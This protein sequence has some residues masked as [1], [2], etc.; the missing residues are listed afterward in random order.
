MSDEKRVQITSSGGPDQM[1]KMTGVPRD[2]IY[3]T[4]NGCQWFGVTDGKPEFV[5][6]YEPLPENREDE[7]LL[8]FFSGGQSYKAIDFAD[9]GHGF[10][11]ITIQHLCGYGYTPKNY[12]RQSKF[13][14]EC[15]FE[16]CRSK[17]DGEGRYHEL[18]FLSGSFRMRGPLR[19]FYKDLDKGLS[20]DA[21]WAKVVHWICEH[22]S[23][24]TLD[25]CCQRVAMVID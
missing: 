21:K 4:V 15:G 7:Q 8:P 17:R 10:P 13:M 5:P 3:G 11:S 14:E 12:E 18:W 2:M 22:A 16:C 19:D 24:G 23:F 9:V 6:R 1:V 25:I 20:N